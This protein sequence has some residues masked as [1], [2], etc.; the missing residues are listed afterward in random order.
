M[1][2]WVKGSAALDSREWFELVA[3]HLN[4]GGAVSQ[5]L[6]LY[7]SSEFTACFIAGDATAGGSATGPDP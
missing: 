2:P 7:Q 1:H 6:P 4:P 3:R 5:W